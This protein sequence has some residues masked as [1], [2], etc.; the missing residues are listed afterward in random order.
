MNHLAGI[1]SVRLAPRRWAWAGY[2]LLAVTAATALCLL[3]PLWFRDDDG[4]FLRF[5]AQQPLSAAFRP[6]TGSVQGFFRPVSVAAFWLAYRAFG[7]TYWP[8]QFGQVLITFG[9]LA[10]FHA[11]LRAMWG[12]P[13]P[14]LA[15]AAIHPLAFSGLYYFTFRFS[16]VNY[17]LEL[18]LGFAAAGLGAAGWRRRSAPLLAAA[19]LVTEL[20][21]GAKE[22]SCVWLPILQAWSAIVLGRRAGATW[23]PVAL[24]LAALAALT[25]WHLWLV[26]GH[27]TLQALGGQVA[28]TPE[29]IWQRVAYY[30]SILR[31]GT[32]GVALAALGA[33]ACGAQAAR[34]K[35]PGPWRVA[36]VLAAASAAGA[37]SYLLHPL[38]AVVAASAAVVPAWPFAL[39][40]T[41]LLA[42]IAQLEPMWAIYIL[43]ASWLMV[44]ALVAAI[45]FSPLPAA[46][47]RARAALRAKA[48]LDL[49]WLAAA[50]CLPL[51]LAGAP[52]ALRMVQALEA[53]SCRR[54]LAGNL[55]MSLAATLPLHSRLALAVWE[56]IGT[57]H[58]Q[59]HGQE[60]LQRAD[61]LIQWYPGVYQELLS[62]LGRPDIV[63]V[64]YGD[65]QRPEGFVL[66]TSLYEMDAARALFARLG[67]P[68]PPPLV[69]CRQGRQRGA[70]WM[71][72]K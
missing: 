14:A 72:G 54:C 65:L 49:R 48:G 53:T 52:K 24:F 63:V 17:Q 36:G 69:S 6:Q 42:M 50:A 67:A 11:M 31:Q 37:V 51:V 44:A 56:D 22:P 2:A 46:A 41:A 27:F 62:A 16:Q 28:L 43:Q 34:W 71:L 15:A 57:T 21:Y 47:G 7:W 3:F 12:R 70:L 25:A 5:A 10:A 8:Y 66:A 30:S 29:F 32:S 58:Q 45:A 59:Q 55:T 23:K 18:L 38:P 1:G 68:M 35:A 9:I 64:T 40:A 60:Y 33:L 20:A 61:A 19:L 4:A 39:G 26:R 13:W